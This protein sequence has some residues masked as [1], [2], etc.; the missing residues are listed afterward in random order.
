MIAW[1]PT[2]S[3]EG[4]NL[5]THR[6][7]GHLRERFCTRKQRP[8]DNEIIR[9]FNNIINE[10]EGMADDVTHVVV[11]IPSTFLPLL[12]LATAAFRLSMGQ[13]TTGQCSL[14][15]IYG[16]KTADCTNLNLDSLPRYLDGD[17][18][19]LTFH[20]NRLTFL[21][22]DSFQAYSSLQNLLLVRNRLEEIAP[23]AFRDLRN[24][25]KLDL[26]GNKLKAIPV[27][28][29]RHLA[30]L[31]FLSLKSNP[32]AY[33]TNGDL[34]H[35]KN[36]EELNFENC[37]LTR[38]EPR[39]FAELSILNE[40]NLVNNELRG[41]D[42]DMEDSLSKTLTII[43][44][45]SNP[46]Q[47]DCRLRWL[48]KLLLR[49]PNWEF[50]PNTP[51]CAGPDLIRGVSWKH[52][53]PDQFACPSTIVGNS[54]TSIELRVGSNV[55]IECIVF[56]DP[57]PVVTW[58][59][60]PKT[61]GRESISEGTFMSGANMKEKHIRS[62][63]V[64]RD[65]TPDDASDYKCIAVNPAGRSEVTYKVWIVGTDT[66]PSPAEAMFSLGLEVILGVVIAGVGLVV[67]FLL[68]VCCVV[69]KQRTRRRE[70][71]K[72]QDQELKKENA[73]SSGGIGLVD[74]G[75]EKSVVAL[76]DAQAQQ[77]QNRETLLVLTSVVDQTPSGKGSPVIRQTTLP[78][79]NRSD[80]SLAEDKNQCASDE[81]TLTS[82]DNALQTPVIKGE[83]DEFKMKIFPVQLTGGGEL[84][85]DQSSTASNRS[86]ECTAEVVGDQNK[87][88]V[89]PDRIGPSPRIRFKESPPD[90]L[91]DRHVMIN[92]IRD[93]KLERRRPETVDGRDRQ[94][95][96]DAP[97]S[98]VA[99]T[100]DGS[101][102][103][104]R[105]PKIEAFP[106]DR[107]PVAVPRQDSA[108]SPVKVGTASHCDNPICLKERLCNFDRVTTGSPPP[109]A[110]DCP[111]KST[112]NKGHH[113][114]N[115][116]ESTD[117]RARRS[118]VDLD[119][120]MGVDRSDI[121]I[122]GSLRNS[123]RPDAYAT[124][125]VKAS[126]GRRVEFTDLCSTISKH[127]PSASQIRSRHVPPRAAMT[128]SLASDYASTP[129]FKMSTIVNRSTEPPRIA[130]YVTDYATNQART[131]LSTSDW[132]EVN[133]PRSYDY[134]LS[135]HSLASKL[136]GSSS[137]L[138]IRDVRESQTPSLS[139]RT[140]GCSATSLL[141][142]LS[143]PFGQQSFKQK[144]NN[145]QQL[146]KLKPGEQDE[147]G[148]AV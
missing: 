2:S 69:A 97:T 37:W 105:S 88:Q 85:D 100:Q 34:R 78:V 141:D 101:E 128:R 72:L 54:T 130:S 22:M 23:D 90:L 92:S 143:P 109:V 76:E 127:Q 102:R 80:N 98:H 94:E 119:A 142:I 145:Q 71:H 144:T 132:L 43:R 75:D 115:T 73:F 35:L 129:P 14:A 16:L 79:E 55:S 17:L 52:L 25:Q 140:Q 3:D 50:G 32:I 124:L 104:T 135:N 65:I 125:P 10:F 111:R 61:I 123:Q 70:T 86:R 47:C 116:V 20:G 33:V 68:C 107:I 122:R 48:R 29:L 19:T 138:D 49:I 64:L 87:S 38:I 51:S 28:A 21:G 81:D 57:E 110:T 113:H 53:S 121:N 4:S 1:R 137:T 24:L 74:G 133:H 18:K 146:K 60:G 147:F 9:V 67:V 99:S 13:A 11:V 45:H 148:T 139:R 106:I 108:K 26:E 40:L 6:R 63:V 103:E 44:L 93:K 134:A 84:C 66:S 39:A 36:L 89:S 31:R 77:R 62:V 46:W 56:G 59:K 96:R 126:H 58:L 95:Q 117:K 131:L 118:V 83:Q 91:C 15:T 30:S 27:Q 136:T 112:H 82:E 12:F 114:N 42:A 5:T 120:N 41:L 8:I 7:P